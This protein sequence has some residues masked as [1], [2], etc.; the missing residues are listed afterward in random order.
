M[1][2]C[3]DA[4]LEN[5]T[6]R[7]AKSIG[8]FD[9]GHSNWY[10]GFA[11]KNGTLAGTNTW[12][13]TGNAFA[14][15]ND[16]GTVDVAL[17]IGMKAA[18]I[19]YDMYEIQL[20]GLTVNSGRLVAY[21]TKNSMLLMAKIDRENCEVLFQRCVSNDNIE[22]QMYFS[23]MNRI[24]EWILTKLTNIL[25]AY[26]ELFS[27]TLSDEGSIFPVQAMEQAFED[28]GI[29]GKNVRSL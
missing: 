26:S 19:T 16:D 15:A 5:E 14:V 12:N 13:R 17:P 25:L 11:L 24:G 1:N 18:S 7:M 4:L 6:P 22:L 3:A 23:G 9:F 20:F 10:V 28:A 8:L 2:R 29:C 21:V 27:F